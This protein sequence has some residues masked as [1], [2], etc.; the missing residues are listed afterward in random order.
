MINLNKHN[1]Q[2]L[3][4][5]DSTFIKSESLEIISEISLQNSPNSM[6]VINKI[7]ELTYLA[8]S[9]KISFA[10]ALITRIKLLKANKE[11]IALTIQRVK[12]EI[13]DSFND[14]K[15]FFKKNHKNCYIISGGFSQ[16]IEPIMKEFNIPKKNIFANELIF[17]KEGYIISINK[18]NPL[19]K[20]LG[21]IAIAKIIKG[22]KIIIGDG[23]TDYEIKKYG[24]AFK[25]IQ[26]TENINRKNLNTNADFISKNLNEALLYIKKTY[27]NGKKA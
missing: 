8:M 10:D 19:S 22:K 14:N 5:F 4:D 15:A 9:G 7:K 11:H 12:G 25:F 16:I 1:I 27:Q 24:F 2:L 26:Y 23:Y 6:E 18:N 20:D 3:I 21:K 17:N 13:S